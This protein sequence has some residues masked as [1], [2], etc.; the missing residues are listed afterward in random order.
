M[1]KLISCAINLP[2]SC[3]GREWCTLSIARMTTSATRRYEDRTES[4]RCCEY[5]IV[6]CDVTGLK[7]YPLRMGESFDMSIK[8]LFIIR[9]TGFE[10]GASLKQGKESD[11]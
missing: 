7:L 8:K 4:I 3:Q 2:E 6:K 9:D 1:H 10:S 11:Q 5:L